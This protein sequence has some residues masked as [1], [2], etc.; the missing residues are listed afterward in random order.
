MS[1]AGLRFAE[2][3]TGHVDFAEHDHARAATVGRETGNRLTLRLTIAIDDLARFSVDPNR[4]AGIAG[5]VEWEALGGRLP[6][7]GGVFNLLVPAG[8]DGRRMR[9]R[10]FVR[11]G[12][13]HQVTLVGE[14]RV[15]PPG[16]RVWA[17]T[18]TLFVRAVRGWVESDD[19]DAELV[20][21]GI[22][23]LSPLG[24]L[25]QL[26][27]FRADGRS[28]AARVGAIARFDALFARQLWLAY[29]PPTI[30]RLLRRPAKNAGD[31]GR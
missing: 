18:T 21:A 11:D 30:R 26:T 10:L 29:G 24:F 27:T 7:E 28:P 1:G 15:G 14:K 20:A 13:G 9:Y 5:E 12:V 22:V 17:D 6:V 16:L 3:M 2:V 19:D 23:R 25:R 4:P 8:D 31:G